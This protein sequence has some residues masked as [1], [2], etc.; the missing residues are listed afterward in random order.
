MSRKSKQARSKV[1][2]RAR[3]VAPFIWP[4][5]IEIVPSNS[6]PDS[7]WIKRVCRRRNFSFPFWV[8]MEWMIFTITTMRTQ[9]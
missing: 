2:S 7:A 9:L 3:R 4:I 1:P 8:G 6:S 5:G